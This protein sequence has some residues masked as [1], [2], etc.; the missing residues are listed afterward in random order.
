MLSYLSISNY[1]VIESVSLD[2]SSGLNIL[3]GE[4]GAGKSVIIG[5]INLILGERFNKT[6]IRDNSKKVRIEG[7]FCGNL[8]YL[9]NELREEFEITDEILIKREIDI[10]G[11]NKIYINGQLATLKQLKS[12]TS[13]CID[14]HGQHEHQKL[15]NPKYHL[16]YIDSRIDKKI[17]S[18][19]EENFNTYS[20][21]LNIINKLKLEL[22]KTLREKDIFEFQ[23][24]EIDEMKIDP[25]KETEL[26]QKIEYLSN[27]EKINSGLSGAATLMSESE[28]NICDSMDNVLGTLGDITRF[29]T[30]IDTVYSRLVELNYEL[31]DCKEI[32]ADMLLNSDSDTSELDNIMKRKYQLDKLVKKYGGSLQEVIAYRDS[33]SEKLTN[34]MFD[35]EKISILEKDIENALIDLKKQ[36]LTINNLRTKT[37]KSFSKMIENVLTELDLKNTT[38]RVDFNFSDIPDKQAGAEAEFFISTNP[39]FPPAPLATTASGGEISR[40]MLGL[41]EIFSDADNTST[42]VFDE[43]DT[44]ISGKT[45]DKV[46]EKLYSLANRKQLIVITHLPVVAAKGDIHFHIYKEVIEN[47]TITK[48]KI[49][50]KQERIETIATMIA[51]KISETSMANASELLVKVT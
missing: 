21:N 19:Y 34:Q 22:S 14:I 15:L 32:I 46:G 26:D 2:F 7:I 11:K 31:K 24:S 49:L 25:D 40:V 27:I 3:T 17:L 36:I 45:A 51:G 30:D 42:L 28:V 20:I 29:S 44:G 10:S 33:I 1:S 9:S 13:D 5:A 38:F 4:T 43:I 6:M 37:A 18:T 35:E 16:D 41:K 50:N 12:V 23:L 47:K 48:I 8:N 39:G